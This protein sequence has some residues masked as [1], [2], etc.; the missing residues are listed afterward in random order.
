MLSHNHY[1]T[2]QNESVPQRRRGASGTD[3]VSHMPSGYA[4]ALCSNGEIDMTSEKHLFRGI[5]HTKRGER[6]RSSGH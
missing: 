1:S 6:L 2:K 4:R 5:S 3:R